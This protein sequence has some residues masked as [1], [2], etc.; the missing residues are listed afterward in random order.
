MQKLKPLRIRTHSTLGWTERYAP[1]M[2]RAGFLPLARIVQDTIPVMDS[3]A[4]TA[5]L[6]RWR[7]ETHTFH[8][9][10]GELTVTLQVKLHV[11][12]FVFYNVHAW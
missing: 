4:L 2:A 9:P 12:N 1:Y 5:L 10:C 3:A 7:P 8:L 11:Y 6:D